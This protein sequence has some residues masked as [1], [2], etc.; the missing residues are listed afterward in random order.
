[1]VSVKFVKYFIVLLSFVCFSY[2]ASANNSRHYPKHQF[3]LGYSSISGAGLT[4]QLDID[5]LN[6]LR[7]NFFAYYQGDEPPDKV[8]LYSNIGLEYQFNLFNNRS[9]RAYFFSGMSYWLIEKRDYELGYVNDVLTKLADNELYRL[10]NFGLGLGYEVKFWERAAFSISLGLQYQ[11]SEK[12]NLDKLFDRNP[13][14]ESF[15]GIGGG[16]GLRYTF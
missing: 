12:S 2:S 8:K 16:L 11:I 1:M 10:Y 3:G 13:N 5:K 9:E 4:Y 7:L 6:T 15:L 14:G